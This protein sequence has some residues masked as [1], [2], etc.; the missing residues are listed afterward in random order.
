MPGLMLTYRHELKNDAAPTGHF[1]AFRGSQI[2]VLIGLSWE[3][4]LVTP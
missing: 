1:V 3:P 4:E 2:P